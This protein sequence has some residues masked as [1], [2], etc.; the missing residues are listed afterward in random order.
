MAEQLDPADQAQQQRVDFMHDHPPSAA[1]GG[2]AA[3]L[4]KIYSA[5]AG[6][7]RALPRDP[8]GDCGDAGRA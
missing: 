4:H 5:G 8:A 1:A 6:P 3:G 2:G 7:N